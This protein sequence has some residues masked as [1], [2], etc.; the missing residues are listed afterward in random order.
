[1]TKPYRPLTP[2]EQKA[3]VVYDKKVAILR[4]KVRQA[5]KG[6]KLGVLSWGEG[7]VGKSFNVLKTF[8]ELGLKKDKDYI[9]TNSRMSAVGL[10]D[11]ICKHPAL[12]HYLE[13]IETLFEQR[14]AFGFL[15]SLL[16]GQK[17]ENGVMRRYAT[18]VVH[19]N[20]KRLEFTGKVI[21]TANCPLDDL[22]EL[23]ALG[24]RIIP[25]RLLATNP[26]LLAQMKTMCNRGYTYKGVTLTPE[27]CFGAYDFYLQHVP[28][29]RHHDLRILEHGWWNIIDSL[30]GVLK[31]TTWQEMF[32]SEILKGEEP[33]VTRKVRIRNEREIALELY[34]LYEEKKI[35]HAEMH[36]RWE[37]LTTHASLDSLYRRLRGR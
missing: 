24:T 4:D 23:R 7:G 22:P 30:N 3:L 13:D 37:K 18:S 20:E 14:S 10:E 29:N 11:L 17:D 33:P 21:I 35:S 5:V 32:L 27:K 2:A 15:R 26:Q 28:E 36:A 19:G 31:E 16:W 25:Y 12:I 6:T 34:D 8:D 1:M 9:L